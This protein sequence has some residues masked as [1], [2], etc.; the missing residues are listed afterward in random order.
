MADNT[1]D[2]NN[3]LQKYMSEVQKITE[4]NQ[5]KLGKY[6]QDLGNYNAKIQK[7]S[8][9]YQW[10]QNQYVQL[11][12]EYNQGIQMLIGAGVPQQKQQKG[13]R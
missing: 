8:V 7:H 5:S 3:N 9:D 12:G 10:Y 13:E 1:A 2:F 6:A 11:K 4:V